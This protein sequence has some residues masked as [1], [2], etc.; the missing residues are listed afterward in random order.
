MRSLA[1]ATTP[2]LDNHLKRNISSKSKIAALIAASALFLAFARVG[3]AEVIPCNRTAPWEGNVGVPGGIPRRTKIYRNIV[4]DLGADAAGAKDCSS[5][6]QSA[7]N[8]CPSGQVIYIPEGRFRVE[9]SVHVGNETPNRTLRGAGMGR[10]T[11]FGPQNN[12]IF[13]AGDPTWPPPEE[14]PANWIAITSGATQGS[15]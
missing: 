3:L 14:D 11:L 5:I 15:N 9:T 6:I 12:P 7:I 2:A 1:S 13:T 8:K 10:T 4:T